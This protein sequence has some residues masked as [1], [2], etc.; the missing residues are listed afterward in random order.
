MSFQT[1]LDAPIA[2]AVPRV[3]GLEFEVQEVDTDRY[4]GPECAAVR[5]RGRKSTPGRY[6]Q[7]VGPGTGWGETDITEPLTMIRSIV[8]V[9]DAENPWPWEATGRR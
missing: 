9:W 1:P 2:F 3:Q 8:R 4:L 6:F 7:V 5:M